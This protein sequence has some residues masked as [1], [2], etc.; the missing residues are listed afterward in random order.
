M[1]A[2]DWVRL[3]GAAAI[4]MGAPACYVSH[5]L[6]GAASSDAGPPVEVDA[7][8]PLPFAARTERVDFDVQIR[9]GSASARLTFDVRAENASGEAHEATF[10]S[11]RIRVRRG[12]RIAEGT[13]AVRPET[14]HVPAHSV[15][16]E[17]FVLR[18]DLEPAAVIGWDC[19][20]P[21]E[22]EVELLM[23]TGAHVHV[24]PVRVGGTSCGLWMP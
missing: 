4:A 15:V 10:E 7:G 17:D 5:E 23:R 24:Y 18:V 14:L 16:H 11:A 20:R 12:S 13:G 3:L 8:P 22:I 21:P 19:P 1:S 6:R 2:R 9:D